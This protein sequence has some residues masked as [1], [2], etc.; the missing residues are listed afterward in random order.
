MTNFFQNSVLL[1][2]WVSR[3]QARVQECIFTCGEEAHTYRLLL[4]YSYRLG[5]LLKS[6]FI[7]CWVEY[8][9]FLVFE[10]LLHQTSHDCS[11]LMLGFDGLTKFSNILL[12]ITAS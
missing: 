8:I 1:C 5:R 9:P 12:Q 6:I 7:F 11:C 4:I 10:S 3:L 2:E